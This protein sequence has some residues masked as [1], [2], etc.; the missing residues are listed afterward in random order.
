M[1]STDSYAACHRFV[2]PPGT[3][4]I[5]Y[6]TNQLQPTSDLNNAADL[7]GHNEREGLLADIQW[8]RPRLHPIE[9]Q[10]LSCAD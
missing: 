2:I 8:Y 5:R 9:L 1:T 10:G 4:S 7:V 6:L 3:S